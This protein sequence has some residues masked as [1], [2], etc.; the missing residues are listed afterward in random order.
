MKTKLLEHRKKE[1]KE[2]IKDAHKNKENLQK[3]LKILE[4]DYKT[5]KISK[6]GYE[7]AITEVLKG[8]DEKY[9]LNHYEKEII[10]KQLELEKLQEEIETK[11][12]IQNTT[13]IIILLAITITTLI[14]LLLNQKITGFVIGTNENNIT[15]HTSEVNLEFVETKGYTW[16]PGECYK[17]KIISVNLS[18]EVTA[19]KS[20]KIILE[21]KT[22]KETYT[23]LEKYFE[24]NTTTIFKTNTIE[25]IITEINETTNEMQELIVT[26][27]QEINATEY[28]TQSY[29]FENICGGACNIKEIQENYTIKIILDTD[30]TAKINK[31]SY[32]ALKTEKENYLNKT[33][34]LP[35]ENSTLST[36]ITE[37]TNLNIINET[38]QYPIEKVRDINFKTQTLKEIK[39]VDINAIVLQIQ[40]GNDMEVYVYSKQE[41]IY[42]RIGF[43]Q[44]SIN[45]YSSMAIKDNKIFWIST[46]KRILYAYDP[47]TDT[48]YTNAI[49]IHNPSNGERANIIINN[50]EWQVSISD[51]MIYFTNPRFGEVFSDDNT[52]IKLE[53]YTDKLRGL[54]KKQLREEINLPIIWDEP[55][56]GDI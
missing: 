16:I 55:N 44:T 39:A 56:S 30:I 29:N 50:S 22:E 54:P 43:N 32:T 31:I 12:R 37:D 14:P 7:S 21:L 52:D 11:K 18:G 47:K 6:L 13:V 15:T 48:I 17:C 35:F 27:E 8:K 51:T 34:N 45:Q 26:E 42:R 10:E 4:Y 53:Y 20:G 41:N 46:N 38:N 2:K 25:K 33:Y 5:K 9:W 24:I 28:E 23:I 3:F 40:N 19:N 49:P 1:L 36:N